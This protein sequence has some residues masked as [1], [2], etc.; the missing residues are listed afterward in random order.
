MAD[1][2]LLFAGQGAQRVGMG[3]DLMENSPLARSRFADADAILGRSLSA[4]LFE[5]PDVELTKTA[6]C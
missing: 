6:N 1:V 5:G 3:Q 4:I 2:V